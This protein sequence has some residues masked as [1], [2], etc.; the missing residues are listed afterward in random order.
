VIALALIVTAGVVGGSIGR[1]TT[2]PGP[3]LPEVAAEPETPASIAPSADDRGTT[4]TGTPPPDPCGELDVPG[5]AASEGVSEPIALG[6]EPVTS[7]AVTADYRFEGNLASSAGRAPDLVALGDG[8][9]TF[10]RDSVFG[11]AGRTVLTFA[12]GTGLS[13]SPTTGVID[14]EEYTIEIVFRFGLI[15]GWRKI[16]DFKDGTDDSGLYSFF[17]CPSFFPIAIAT[18]AAIEADP[19][20]QVVLTRDASEMVVGY[21]DGVRRFSFRDTEGLAVINDNDTL[22]FFVDDAQTTGESSGGGVSRIRLYDGPLT[23]NEVAGIACSEIPETP[24][25]LATLEYAARADAICA[26]ASARFY[27]ATAGLDPSQLADLAAWSAAAARFSE[28]ALAELYTLPPPEAQRAQLLEYYLLLERQTEVL[29]ETAAVASE[30]A[31][32]RAERLV[33]KRVQLTHQKDSML[34]S[35]QRCPVFLPA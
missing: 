1:S 17:G 27:A 30:G 12:P 9:K 13:L 7:A 8:S 2:G 16:V 29:R 21:V 25:S 23:G 24:C 4:S 34:V 28:E 19:Y 3:A 22:R 33:R 18:R 35:L 10:A 32:A 11:D 26:Q 5:P 15:D 14:A 31:S 6:P 20:V